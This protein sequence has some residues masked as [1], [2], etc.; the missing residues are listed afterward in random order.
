MRSGARGAQGR[1]DRGGVAQ[2]ARVGG[3]ARRDGVLAAGAHEA[4]DLV[5]ERRAVGGQVSP[6]E[7]GHTGDEHPHGY[8]P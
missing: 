2:V 7:S 6:G 3:H 1:D 4:V 8:R 5:A